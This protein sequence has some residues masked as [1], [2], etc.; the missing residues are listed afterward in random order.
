MP[1]QFFSNL[2]RDTEHLTWAATEQV[3]ERGRRRTRHTR[4]AAM[5]AGAVAVAVVATGAVALA[6]GQ[7]AAPT[8]VL[9]ATGSPTPTPPPSGTPT[10]SPTSSPPPA[11]RTTPV[12]PP[13]SPSTTSGRP[14]SGSTDSAIPAEAMLRLSDLPVGFKMTEGD[15][16]GDWSLES[17]SIYCRDVPSS[18]AV[19]RIAQ[20]TRSF[21]SPTDSMIQRVTRYSGGSAPTAVDQVRALFT[22]CTPYRAGSSLSV[23]AD[24][25]GAGDESLLV[26]STI[27]G[28]RSRWLVV[29]QGDLVA[30]VMLDMDATPA[31][32]R[33]YARPVAQRLCAGTDA[34]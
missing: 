20:R 4:V 11:T 28:Q 17:V 18:V 8:P 3:R 14:T 26:G 22:G 2:Y 21:D 1:D 27:E 7:D 15:I 24:G 9:P 32:A 29:R 12:T 23:L 31:E 6:G 25:L 30:Q 16:D 33:R 5:L 10:P 34:C 19:R 13:S